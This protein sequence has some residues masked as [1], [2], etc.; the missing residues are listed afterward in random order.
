MRKLLPFLFLLHTFAF[1]GCDECRDTSCFTPP[2]PL[3]FVVKNADTGADWFKS[4]SID[5]RQLSVISVVE[6]LSHSIVIEDQDS[7]FLFRNN[8]IGWE[9]GMGRDS[10]ALRIDTLS[11]PFLYHTESLTEDC[12]GFFDIIKVQMNGPSRI[13]LQENLITVNIEL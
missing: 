2:A 3:F 11:I 12:C 8:E 7:I 13:D 1:F 6:N 9:T 10:Y 4:K 5:P